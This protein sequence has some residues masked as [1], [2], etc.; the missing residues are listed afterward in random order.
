MIKIDSKNFTKIFGSS[1]YS[2]KKP[3]FRNCK[4]ENEE[5]KF[6]SK[7]EYGRYLE[8]KADLAAGFISH[9]ERQVR[10]SFIQNGVTLTSYI[11]DFRYIDKRLSEVIVEDFKSA[12]TLKEPLFRVKAKMM[13]AF[14]NVD[15]LI[16]EKKGKY[17]VSQKFSVRRN[18][19]KSKR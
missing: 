7:N 14:F 19:R 5:G 13:R 8:L 10:Y 15:V 6:D 12:A 11:A 4:I 2:E 17:Y 18:S 1:S 9:L 3:K 16:T